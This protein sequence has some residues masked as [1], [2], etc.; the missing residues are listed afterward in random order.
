MNLRQLAYGLISY[1]PWIPESLYKGTGGTNSAAYCYCI[2][3]RHLA[4]AHSGGMRE[5]PKVVAELGPGDSIGVGLAALLS[6]VDRYLA[7][8]ALSHADAAVNV[9]IFDSLVQMF[10]ERA[11][12]PAREVFSE[13]TLELA[14]Y[15][16]PTHILVEERLQVAL[17]PKRIAWLRSIVCGEAPDSRVIDYRAPWGDVRDQDI[18]SV[19]FLLSNAVMEHVS[20]LPAAYRAM[21]LWLRPN[22][23]ASNHIDFRS[24]GLFSTWDGHWACPE[25]LW[26]L[27]MG[28]RSYL[29]N[30]APLT[31]HRSLA[32]TTG[33]V[34]EMIIRVE[35]ES[36][37]K[38]LAPR[39]RCMSLEDRKT[40]GAYVL[41][42]KGAS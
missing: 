7:L 19:D 17:N 14:S 37:A 15:A 30:R 8:D 21:S 41:L 29:L 2:W 11:T 4:L 9:A 25:W 18:G 40:C 5:V 3:L 6:G 32:S 26:R 27:F 42:R 31:T 22:G 33:L 23:W 24:H 34:E 20:D 1:L 38:Y 16:F 13:H 36:E 28:R 35:R 39:F 10:N 12:I